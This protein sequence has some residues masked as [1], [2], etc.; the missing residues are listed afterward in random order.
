MNFLIDGYNLMHVLGYARSGLRPGQL[1]R[2]RVRFLDWVAK[3]ATGKTATLCLV[4]D[5]KNSPVRSPPT[6]H[7]GLWVRYAYGR[8]ADDEIEELL[9]AKPS[10]RK[11]TVVSNDTRLQV[12]GRRCGGGAMSCQEFIDWLQTPSPPRNT[13]TSQAPEKPESETSEE[14]AAWIAAFTI[15]PRR[16]S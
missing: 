16:R 13:A 4:F 2:A 10:S 14:I 1:E 9:A 3:A 7:K 8:T 12:A 6:N 5:A 11:L 15:P